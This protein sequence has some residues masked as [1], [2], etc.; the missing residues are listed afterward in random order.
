[1]QEDR[2]TTEEEGSKEEDRQEGADVKTNVKNELTYL[3]PQG[4]APASRN[5]PTMGPPQAPKAV[6][7][8]CKTQ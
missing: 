3:L 4:N 2:Q 1:M 7:A 6:T 8:S 5:T